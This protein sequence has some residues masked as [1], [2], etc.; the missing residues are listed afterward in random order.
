MC[1]ERETQMFEGGAPR[2]RVVD[3][4]RRASACGALAVS[5]RKFRDELSGTPGRYRGTGLC[6]YKIGEANNFRGQKNA[7]VSGHSAGSRRRERLLREEIIGHRMSAS[8]GAVWGRFIESGRG[9]AL[10]LFHQPAREHRAGVFFQPLIEQRADFF[11]QVGGVAKT[12]EFVR[13]Q[14]SA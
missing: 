4:L 5:S 11:A 7:E 13:L 10:A 3:S 6:R 12:G 1:G 9:R 2:L 8:L 14:G